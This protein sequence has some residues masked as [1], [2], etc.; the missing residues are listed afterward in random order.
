[1]GDAVGMTSGQSKDG[2]GEFKYVLL[3]GAA[4]VPFEAPW[5]ASCRAAGVAEA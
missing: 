5:V 4:A 2:S 3:G 1:V